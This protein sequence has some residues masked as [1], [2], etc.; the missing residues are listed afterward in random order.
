[1]SPEGGLLPGKSRVEI[2]APVPGTG[3][4]L[5]EG[6][7]PGDELPEARVCD[8]G[9]G[10]VCHGGGGL[11]GATAAQTLRE[12]AHALE[13]DLASVD[14]LFDAGFRMI[15]F[16]HFFD[17]EVGGSA[18]GLDKGGLTVADTRALNRSTICIG[19]LRTFKEQGIEFA[20]PTQ[21]TFTAAPDGT[22]RSLIG[23][24]STGW[25]ICCRRS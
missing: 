4:T 20:Y 18:H 6:A 23:A 21:T 5:A 1:M 13:G 3:G 22:M 17:N 11:A 10:A 7:L 15:G 14:V 19:L 9:D 16:T 2:D 8:G 25:P 24:S 12:G